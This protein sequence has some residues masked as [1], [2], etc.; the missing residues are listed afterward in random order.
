ME[1]SSADVPSSDMVANMNLGVQESNNSLNVD[2]VHKAFMSKMIPSTPMEA[3][4]FLSKVEFQIWRAL[5]ITGHDG[6]LKVKDV[7]FNWC[8][9]HDP[10]AMSKSRI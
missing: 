6:Y 4:A 5:A 10:M 7:Q 1:S 3:Q 2:D 9:V 8:K